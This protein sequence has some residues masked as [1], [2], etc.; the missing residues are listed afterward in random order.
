MA[1]LVLGRVACL[2]ARRCKLL[3]K[4]SSSLRGVS[5][6]VQPCHP[7][8]HQ[9]QCLHSASSHSLWAVTLG[10]VGSCVSQQSCSSCNPL[11]PPVL[12]AMFT[13]TYHLPQS[14]D[15][16]HRVLALEDMLIFFTVETLCGLLSALPR[17]L[18]GPSQHQ[19]SVIK[20]VLE[21]EDFGVRATWAW[22]GQRNL[23][24][25]G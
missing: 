19:T 7:E 12:R 9:H 10:S 20:A 18:C 16:L 25:L 13:D 8:V 21:P 6:V 11:V 22:L 5:F 17:S 2:Q 1:C 14:P 3:H 4:R 24:G 15:L 23:V